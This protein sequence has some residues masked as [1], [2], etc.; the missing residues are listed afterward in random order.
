MSA[1]ILP[2][3]PLDKRNLGESVANAM[4]ARPVTPFVALSPF[5]GA[6]V[7]AIYYAGDFPAYREIAARNR[8]QR[9]GL[10]IYVGK[11]VPAGSRKGGMGLGDSPGQALYKRL[12]DHLESIEAATNLAVG[13]F[14]C[15][16]LPVDDIWIPLGESLLIARFSPVWNTLID[17]FG[18]HDPGK[19]RHAGMRP[20]WDTLHPGRAWAER[21][22]PRRESAEAIQREIAEILA[23][24]P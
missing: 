23:A 24:L 3:N 13:D 11:A 20:R 17:G 4:L 2:F 15:R 7:Y 8:G 9:W 22:T 5:T 19:G 18:N 16:F 10:P 6:G 12:R 14:S 21:L 1:D